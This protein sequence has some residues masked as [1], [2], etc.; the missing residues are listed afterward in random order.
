MNYY[1]LKL[2]FS[3]PLHIGDSGSAKSLDT[4][5]MIIRA[6]TL[7]SALCHMALMA[8]GEN[9]IKELYELALEGQLV[10]SDT[11]PYCGERLF[12]PKPTI[13]PNRRNEVVTNDR[14]KMKKINFLPVD[15]Y[16][17][18][19]SFINGEALFDITDIECS[20]GSH[21]VIDKV[22]VRG[23]DIPTPYSIGLFSFDN[24]KQCGLYMIIGCDSLDVLEKV[25]KLMRY[26]GLGGI[27]G[28]VSSGYGKFEIIE[29][30]DINNSSDSQIS[31]L[32][33]MLDLAGKDYYILM[34]TSLPADEELDEAM[35][36]STY[37]LIRRGGFIQSGN[38]ASYSVKKQTQYF[39]SSG[40]VFRKTFS[41]SVY[42]VSRNMGHPVY[43]YSKPMFLGVKV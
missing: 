22:S 17:S 6:D 27:G 2:R 25:K 13:P 26:A 23:L 41:G 10:L 1:L 30:I 15:K 8:D 18:Y 24:E 36:G 12:L 34:T 31:L 35:E 14:K 4:S 20:F 3:S 32:R 16:E 38:S 37:S 19:F 11:M 28:K 39:F 43:R 7:F 5:G 42:D 40:S 21:F 33:N 29:E 9:G